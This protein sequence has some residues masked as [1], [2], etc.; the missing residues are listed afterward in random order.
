MNIASS[1]N[2]FFQKVKRKVGESVVGNDFA[3][4]DGT[5]DGIVLGATAGAAVGGVLGAGRGLLNQSSDQ[6][7]EV[8]L[9]RNITD[10]VL[11]GHRYYVRSDWSTHCTGFDEYRHCE[12]ELD[13]WWHNYSPRINDRLI[14]SYSE[15]ALQHS[16]PGTYL[17]SA[18]AGA[19]IGAGVGTGLGL[20][21]GVL[22]KL[23]GAHPLEREKLPP[24]VRE[25]LIDDTGNNVASSTALGAGIGATLGLAAGLMEQSGAV[26]VSRV[27][28]KPVTTSRN[29]GEIPRNHYEWNHSRWEWGRPGNYQDHSPRGNTPVYRQAPVLNSRGRPEMVNATK[30]LDSTRFGA[31][32]GLVGGAALGAG[33]GFGVRRWRAVFDQWQLG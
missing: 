29:I 32:S 3:R 28:Q 7:T 22:G 12:R 11:Q 24:E 1:L 17:G 23:V 25:K 26:K 33:V 21:V 30:E 20:A 2:N 14:G 9:P 8:A 31:V 27:W 13:G 18:V 16:N 10:P 4:Q 5:V 6:V 19:A 15:P